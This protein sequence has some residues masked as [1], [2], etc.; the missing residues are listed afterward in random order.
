MVKPGKIQLAEKNSWEDGYRSFFQNPTLEEIINELCG[1]I[2]SSNKFIL[3]IDKYKQ[4]IRVMNDVEGLSSADVK[5]LDKFASGRVLTENKNGDSE[6]GAGT[7]CVFR[8]LSLD[9]LPDIDITDNF[10][11]NSNFSF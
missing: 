1:S 5:R 9:E 8:A 6:R 10:L 7:R 2:D 3:K 4:N 11:S